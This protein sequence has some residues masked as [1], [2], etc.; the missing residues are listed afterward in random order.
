MSAKEL[1]PTQLDAVC[2]QL[3]NGCAY[4]T[5]CTRAGV[6]VQALRWARYGD[7]AIMRRCNVARATGLMLRAKWLREKATKLEAQARGLRD[8]GFLQ[9]GDCDIV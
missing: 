5:A 3:D 4:R 6:N 9:R 8:D 1:T 7:P 2:E